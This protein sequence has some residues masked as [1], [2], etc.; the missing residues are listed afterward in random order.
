LFKFLPL[1]ITGLISSVSPVLDDNYLIFNLIDAII[2]TAI[3]IGYLYLMNCSSEL[4][5]VFMYHGA[6]HKSIRTYESGLPLDVKN[7]RGQ[8]RFHPRCGTSF[9]ILVFM[10]SIAVFTVLP[11]DPDF[12][13]NFSVRLLALPLIA[14][15]S[16]EL[17]KYSARSQNKVVFNVLSLPGIFLQRLTTREPDDKILEVALNSLKIALNAEKA[18]IEERLVH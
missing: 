14:G 2:K 1:W 8:S 3:F 11:K 9:I 18:L 15:I 13:I 4:R 12:M 16:Y 5:R 6:E 17:L 7:A 10:V